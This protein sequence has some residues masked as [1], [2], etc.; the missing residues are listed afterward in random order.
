LLQRFLALEETHHSLEVYYRNEWV[1]AMN[2]SRAEIAGAADGAAGSKLEIRGIAAIPMTTVNGP[3]DERLGVR[4]D[5]MIGAQGAVESAQASLKMSVTGLL[6]EVDLMPKPAALNRKYASTEDE[7]EQDLLSMSSLAGHARYRIHHE[8]ELVLD[9]AN[10]Q[11]ELVLAP[12][13]LW[14]RPL[15]DSGL[16]GSGMSGIPA[17]DANRLGIRTRT[18]LQDLVGRRRTV[19]VIEPNLDMHPAPFQIHLTEAGEIVRI[20]I[21]GD[22]DMRSVLVTMGGSDKGTGAR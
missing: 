1:G 16:R 14:L 15:I 5:V 6:L 3:L 17:V 9:S 10:E 21:L 8:G 19:H 11:G 13:L 7:M 2:V 4:M 20:T 22:L 18:V 12:S